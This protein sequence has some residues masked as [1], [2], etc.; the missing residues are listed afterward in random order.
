MKGRYQ[1]GELHFGG[2]GLNSLFGDDSR[3]FINDWRLAPDHSVLSQLTTVWR[4]GKESFELPRIKGSSGFVTAFGIG[5]DDPL[6][7]ASAAASGNP[8]D[9][10]QYPLPFDFF[11]HRNCFLRTANGLAV[12]LDNNITSPKPFL[13]RGGI[14]INIGD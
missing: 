6:G 14:R 9:A 11:T 4:F 5:H 7:S 10:Q 3:R 12:H 2:F 8:P 13:S 1:N